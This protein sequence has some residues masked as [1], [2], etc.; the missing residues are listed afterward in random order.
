MVSKRGEKSSSMNEDYNIERM[1]TLD[2]DV[3]KLN[4][5]ITKPTIDNSSKVV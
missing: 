4:S 2:F 3:L 1:K 5:I